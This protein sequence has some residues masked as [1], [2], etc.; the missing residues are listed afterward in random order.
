MF[1]LGTRGG[2]VGKTSKLTSLPYPFVL[3]SFS[4]ILLSPS[5]IRAARKIAKSYKEWG[6]GGQTNKPPGTLQYPLIFWNL[7]TSLKWWLLLLL[8]DLGGSRKFCER[9]WLI[10]IIKK[11]LEYLSLLI[12]NYSLWRINFFCLL[13]FSI[14]NSSELKN[15]PLLR[16]AR[17]SSFFFLPSS[18]VF[19]FHIFFAIFFFVG[20]FFFFSTWVFLI[21]LA[22][23]NYESIDLRVRCI[24]I[25]V[26][27]LMGFFK[28]SFFFFI[29]LFFLAEW[30]KKNLFCLGRQWWGFLRDFFFFLS[31]AQALSSK[32]E[33][34]YFLKVQ[35]N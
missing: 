34:K 4:F 14:Q 24:I 12:E 2:H 10:I 11:I 17:A 29:F 21:K 30:I 28:L 35:G 31:Y 26:Y 6:E 3:H 27:G 13:F 7:K 22:I 33:K 19:P 5:M 25:A 23:H 8:R 20:I 18:I 1:P 32:K 15:S 16:H 9:D